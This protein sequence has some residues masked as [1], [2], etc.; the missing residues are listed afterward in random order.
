[1]LLGFLN[2]ELYASEFIKYVCKTPFI[3]KY[4]L[5]ILQPTNFTLMNQSIMA[6]TVTEMQEPAGLWDLKM[7][8]DL[9][10][11]SFTHIHF[12]NFYVL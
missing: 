7:W 2:R 5:C 10:I 6:V 8:P 9:Q 1:M 12:T 3:L 11:G 4:N